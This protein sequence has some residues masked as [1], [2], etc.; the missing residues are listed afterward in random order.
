MIMRGWFNTLK[1]CVKAHTLKD[2]EFVN[3]KG[4]VCCKNCKDSRVMKIEHEGDK[5]SVGWW[6]E[7]RRKAK[8]EQEERERKERRMEKVRNLTKSS[9]IGKRF[10]EASFASIDRM[11]PKDFLSALERCE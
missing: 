11:R 4:E 9:L 10:E 3:D 1:E 6:C 7:C 5:Y 8:E 2:D